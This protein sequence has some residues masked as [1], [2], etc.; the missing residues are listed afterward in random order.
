MGRIRLQDPE[1]EL[2]AVTSTG[3]GAS[4]TMSRVPTSTWQITGAGTSVGTVEIQGSLNG[5]SWY[6]V[7]TVALTANGDHYV[8]IDEIHRYLRANVTAYTSGNFT[9]ILCRGDN[10]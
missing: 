5:T 7:A 8:F 10:R 3:A 4:N 1:T 6:T 9:V 2:D